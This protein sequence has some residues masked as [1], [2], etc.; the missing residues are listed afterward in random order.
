[1]TRK[2]EEFPE[3]VRIEAARLLVSPEFASVPVKDRE[4]ALAALF[5]APS[6]PRSRQEV[7][8]FLRETSFPGSAELLRRLL[9]SELADARAERRARGIAQGNFQNALRFVQKNYGV[10][11]V[12]RRGSR[13]LAYVEGLGRPADFFYTT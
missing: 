3:S 13:M 7:A 4:R 5:G 9:D 6:G 2:P 11:S 1:M 12:G 10:Q 8:D